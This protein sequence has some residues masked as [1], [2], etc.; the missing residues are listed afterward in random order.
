MVDSKYAV[1]WY[2]AFSNH[3]GITH[4]SR[5]LEHNN[6]FTWG[7]IWRTRNNDIGPE[8]PHNAGHNNSCGFE[9]DLNMN[10]ALPRHSVITNMK[11]CF[12]SPNDSD[13]NELGV[14]VLVIIGLCLSVI[15]IFVWKGLFTFTLHMRIVANG[16]LFLNS[17]WL[18]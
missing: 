17:F 8:G 2:K 3:P 4:A 11:C 16:Q 15:V 18:V 1:N 6:T 13:S 14:T 9:S 7:S 10:G 5:G 12:Y